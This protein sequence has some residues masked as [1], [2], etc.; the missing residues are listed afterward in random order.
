V[1][2]ESAAEAIELIR[3]GRKF[4]PARGTESLALVYSTVL[5]TTAANYHACCG[6][7]DVALAER[8]RSE[9]RDSRDLELV[10]AVAKKVV[11]TVSQQVISG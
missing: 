4:D 8:I 10:G 11:N 6:S 7:D 3:R 1:G 5:L 9:L 2:E